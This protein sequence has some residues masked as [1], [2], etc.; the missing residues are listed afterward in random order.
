MDDGRQDPLEIVFGKYFF[1]FIFLRIIAIEKRRFGVCAR[2]EDECCASRLA[3]A[4][5]TFESR[6]N[7]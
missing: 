6:E 5:D 7:K 3:T 4:P 2:R 1:T